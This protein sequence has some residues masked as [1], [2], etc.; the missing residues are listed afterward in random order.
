M[1]SCPAQIGVLE[2]TSVRLGT[3]FTT[4]VVVLVNVVEQVPMA[5]LLNRIVTSAVGAVIVTVASPLV[6]KVTV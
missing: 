6:S 2:V 3:G 5:I 1:A 4:T